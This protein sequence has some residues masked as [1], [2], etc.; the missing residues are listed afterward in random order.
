MNRIKIIFFSSVLLFFVTTLAIEYLAPNWKLEQQHLYFVIDALGGCVALLLSLV[1]FLLRPFREDGAYLPIPALSFM[2][3]GMSEI[4][5]FF[6]PNY[7]ITT[8][9]DAQAMLIASLFMLQLWLPNQSL[10]IFAKRKTFLFSI[11]FVTISG[12]LTLAFGSRLPVAVFDFHFSP[13]IDSLNLMSGVFFLLAL[14]RI[15]TVFSDPEKSLLGVMIFYFALSGV[16]YPLGYMWGPKWWLGQIV[17]FLPF[18]FA[19]FYLSDLFIRN[20]RE[21]INRQTSLKKLNKELERFTSIASHD[22]KSPL[23]S[24]SSFSELIREK[25]NPL[26]DEELNEYL[27]YVEN[28][29]K[30]LR[31]LIDDLL[32]YARLSQTSSNFAPVDSNQVLDEV[33]GNLSGEIEASQAKI[34]CPKLP[35]VPG[36]RIQLVQLWQNL[37]GNAIKYRGVRAPLV[38]VQYEDKMQEWLF[39]VSDNGIGFAMEHS[40]KIFQEFQRLHGSGKYSG[41]GLGLPICKNIVEKHG[42]KIW[43]KSE[44]D[45]GSTFFFT[46]PKDSVL[47]VH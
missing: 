22:L 43:A 17:Q 7:Q 31:N 20:Q 1:L 44:P 11:V 18:I 29:A 30:R 15:F 9:L 38:K 45:K 47:V 32:S 2:A 28:A 40:E 39:S 8:W 25:T 10:S 19:I 14:P 46:I 12:T 36:N 27:T 24:I 35:Q 33:L 6:T 34:D 5:G 37:L 21:L 41:T 13:Y 16:S 26:H 23:I 42:G 4:L 3:M